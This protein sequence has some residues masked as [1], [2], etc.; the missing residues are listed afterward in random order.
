MTALT[1]TIAFLLFLS[2]ASAFTPQG[3]VKARPHSVDSFRQRNRLFDMPTLDKKEAA[4]DTEE[5]VKSVE[6]EKPKPF[7]GIVRRLK[8][9]VGM[10]PA[11]DDDASKTPQPSQDDQANGEAT[12]TS[13][14][15]S[16]MEI[17]DEEPKDKKDNMMLQIK[18][19]GIAGVIS[20]AA[21]ELL[22]WFFSVPVALVG[23][24]ELAGHWPDFSDKDDM[25]KLGAEA[26]AVVNFARFAVPLRVGL[27]LSTT[28][29][30]KEN[31]VE[32]YL[33]K[34]EDDESQQ[35]S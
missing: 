26:F 28:P 4:N 21:W 14:V 33:E 22:F 27:A 12:D 24:R 15:S 23:Y 32:K 9:L 29:W 30:V 2:T 25:A 7:M 17:V 19:A 10:P 1:A 18:E 31:I 35:E 13:S 20:Y 16:A 8:R 3:A 11:A 5:S 34:E 6:A